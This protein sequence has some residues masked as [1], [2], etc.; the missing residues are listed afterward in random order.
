ML[1]LGLDQFHIATPLSD[2]A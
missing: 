2:D 1:G